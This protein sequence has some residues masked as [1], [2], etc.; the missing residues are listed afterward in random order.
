M[1][2]SAENE[3]KLLLWW[4]KILE[5]LSRQLHFG[6]QQLVVMRMLQQFL[7]SLTPLAEDK[8]STGLLGAI[9][10][11]RKSQLSP[12][13][14]MTDICNPQGHVCVHDLFKELQ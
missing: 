3:A 5:S 9:G 13:Y 14:V 12:R 4:H 6:T 1:N 10:F 2:C 8:A 11:G 7:T